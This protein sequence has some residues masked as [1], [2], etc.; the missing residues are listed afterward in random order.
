MQTFNPFP[1]R[2]VILVEQNSLHLNSKALYV[3]HPLY[4]IPFYACITTYCITV[5]DTLEV[6]KTN[7]LGY[8]L[9]P[10]KMWKVLFSG[11]GLDFG[12]GWISLNRSFLHY[13]DEIS[14]S[15]QNYNELSPYPHIHLRCSTLLSLLSICIAQN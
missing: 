8:A 6:S 7:C 1:I 15:M 3:F 13:L 11:A 5:C 2:L 12:I 10:N 9:R 4:Q 14:L